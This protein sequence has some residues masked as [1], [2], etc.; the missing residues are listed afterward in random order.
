MNDYKI[1]MELRRTSD[2]TIT[3][4]FDPQEAHLQRLLT[5]IRGLGPTHYDK[6]RQ[7]I[8]LRYPKQVDEHNRLLSHL[9]NIFT[10]E[11]HNT[12]FTLTSNH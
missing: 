3:V 9:H 11:C 4:L 10:Y 8:Y 5:R 7:K 12:N 2:Y 6:H 1:M